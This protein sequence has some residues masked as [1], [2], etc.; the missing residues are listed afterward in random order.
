M[1]S[2]VAER[3]IFKMI[4]IHIFYYYYQLS[5]MDSIQFNM[6]RVIVLLHVNR[7]YLRT[8]VHH[9]VVCIGTGIKY[10]CVL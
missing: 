10:V 6:T 5:L 7:T 9:S 2:R 1:F 8:C 3:I 4:T